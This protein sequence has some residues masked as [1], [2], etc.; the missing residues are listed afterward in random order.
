M[1]YRPVRSWV[2]DGLN[3]LRIHRIMEHVDY[4][5]FISDDEWVISA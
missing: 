4:H 3:A 1:G 5:L 2:S